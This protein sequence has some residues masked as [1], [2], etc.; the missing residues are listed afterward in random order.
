MA[1]SVFDLFKIGI[2]PSSSHTVGPMKAAYAFIRNLEKEG[3][4]SST[5]SI[6][7]ELFGSL[8]ATGKGHG[9]DTAVL[10][11]L[12]GESPD[13]VDT[14]AIPA[15][16]AAIRDQRHIKLLGQHRI[17][18]IESVHLILHKRKSLP[19]HPNGMIFYAYDSN[20]NVLSKR[21]YYSIGGGFIVD[22][23]AIEG[24][25][26]PPSPSTLPYPFT[27]AAEL[28]AL[29]K[30]HQ[31]PISQIMLENECVWRSEDTIRHEL[32]QIWHVMQACV[33][34]GCDREGIL[35]GGM[36]VKR[37]AAD[38]HRKLLS[39]P[40]AALRDPLTV[41]DWVNLY[42]LAVNEENAAGG[43]VVTAP[44]NGAAGIIPAV[45]HY[46][47]RFTQQASD[48]GI[49]RFLLTAG[50]IG[51]LFKLNASISGAEV[52]CQGEVG[53]ACSMAAGAL[54]EVLGGSPE[55]VENAAEIA[56]EH[57][58]GLT[59]DPVGGLV[60]VPC[61]ERNAMASIKAINAARMALRGDGQHFVS[62]DR[63][64]KTMRDTGRD[65]NTKYKETA[66]GG[67][68][69]NVVEVPVNI[70]EC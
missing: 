55:Q 59:C 2:G 20:A 54:V 15:M 3:G 69:I 9:S 58:L 26:T 29:C 5:Q 62:L 51:I 11:G 57:N 12:Q 28:L 32:L 31:K 18:F 21:A 65:M 1:I 39:A 68:A 33:A 47:T 16:L 44:T 19:Y 34:R 64:I 45:M 63:V 40:E 35:P 38:L 8:G 50:A 10:L 6:K 67:L 66:R 14:D 36:K 46:Y 37:R 52:G 56:M 60:Q 22:E 43:R 23:V 49:I 30:R 53:S 48:D 24:G 13:T 70:V 42:A 7:V 61:I 41:L 17:E 27:S 25:F 4:L